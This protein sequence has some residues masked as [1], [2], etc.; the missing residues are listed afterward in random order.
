ML[1]IT[2]AAKVDIKYIQKLYFLSNSYPINFGNNSKLFVFYVIY[3][4]NSFVNPL[5]IMQF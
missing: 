1:K 3:H 5:K 2:S 4:V